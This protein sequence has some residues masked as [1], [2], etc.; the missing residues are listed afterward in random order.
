M[1]R[2]LAAGGRWIRT[3]GPGATKRGRV[4]PSSLDPVCRLSGCATSSMSR[5]SET[6]SQFTAG[7]LRSGCRISLSLPKRFFQVRRH[8]APAER[9][10]GC[11]FAASGTRT[12]RPAVGAGGREKPAPARARRAARPGAIAPI[13]EIARRLETG[14]QPIRDAAAR[15]A[16]DGLL[17]I[18]PQIGCRVPFPAPA[19]VADFFLL[20]AAAEALV[21]RLGAERRT[22]D[23]A[24]A[25]NLAQALEIEAAAAGGPADCDPRYRAINRAF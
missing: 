8:A 18:V 23:E 7:L 24:R 4:A 25:F 10:S 14:R 9:Q 22:P 16:T 3:L 2:R 13:G 11:H 5:G 17:E 12:S 20:F 19:V 6:T 21:A 15:L 1:V